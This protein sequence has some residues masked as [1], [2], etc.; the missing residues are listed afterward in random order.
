MDEKCDVLVV[1]AGLVG[2][3]TAYHLCQQRS[4]R[5]TVL[6]A[7]PGPAYHQSGHNSGVIHSGLYYRPGSLRAHLCI[8][9]REQLYAFCREHRIPHRKTG[10]WIVA[11]NQWEVERLNQ[12]YQN[13]LANGLEGLEFI[14]GSAAGTASGMIRA[15]AALLVPHTGIVSF[16]KVA[17]ALVEE[18]QE[19]GGRVIFNEPVLR[20]EPDARGVRVRTR[21]STLSARI[22]IACAGLQADRLARRS[23]LEPGVRIIPFRGEYFILSDRWTGAISRPIYPVP[24]PDLPFLGIHLTPDLEGVVHIGPNALLTLHRH[25]YTRRA[26]SLRDAWE[27]LTYRG[28]WRLMLRHY[29]VGLTEWWRAHALR[30]MAR[31]VRKYLPEVSARDLR[32]NGAGVRAM[33]V[34]SDGHFVDDFL[35]LEGP[36]ML[37]VLNAPSPA[38]T[39]SL[40]IGLFL[41][42]RTLES[43]S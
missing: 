10:K 42:T 41:S 34:R 43:L 29:R 8:Q 33:A 4:L 26:F 22:A 31:E 12:L 16:R 24:H 11:F 36:R 37:H 25:G 6:E 32:R 13:G 3:A 19:H 35:I 2:L 39:A 15:K 1:G 20:L 38:A 17:A 21:S 40:A 7:E 5:V 30:R 18:I 28:T 23:G 14:E 9:G 27:T